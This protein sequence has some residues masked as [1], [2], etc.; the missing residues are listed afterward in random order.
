MDKAE[1]QR[2]IAKHQALREQHPRHEPPV[3]K[4]G[5]GRVVPVDEWT[6]WVLDYLR[7]KKPVAQMPPAFRHW[8][9]TRP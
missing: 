5:Q 2:R 1:V 4:D 9:N 3:I 7:S 8:L 6:E